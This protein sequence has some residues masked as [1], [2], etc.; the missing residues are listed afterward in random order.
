[1]SGSVTV[2]RIVNK[3]VAEISSDRRQRWSGSDATA[4]GEPATRLA[5]PAAQMA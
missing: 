1:V 2:V 5:Q 4:G 3:R